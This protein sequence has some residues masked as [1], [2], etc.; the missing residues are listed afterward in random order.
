[1]K[2]ERPKK[3]IIDVTNMYS[4]SDSRTTLKIAVV[5][6]TRTLQI[7]TTTIMKKLC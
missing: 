6:V 1:M 4:G 3:N 2:L 5:V 7:V